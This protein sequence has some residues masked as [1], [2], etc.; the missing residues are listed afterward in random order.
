MK[1]FPVHYRVYLYASRIST[2]YYFFMKDKYTIPTVICRCP[3]L[4]N[5]GNGRADHS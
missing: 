2:L 4:T 1:P 5:T 3:L